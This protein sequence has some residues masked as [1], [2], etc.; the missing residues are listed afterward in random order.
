[1]PMKISAVIPAY[2]SEV[3]IGRA[4]D[5]VLKQTRPADEV[6]VVDDGST[7]STAEIIRSYGDKVHL[8][9]QE[10]AGVSV[11]RNA[12]VNA[13][14]GDWIAF[15]DADDEWLP[16]KLK[17]QTEHL[18]RNPDLKW[19]Y[20]NY[21]RKS[22]RF[23]KLKTAHVSSRLTGVLQGKE[24]VEDYFQAEPLGGHVWTCTLVV[25]KSVFEKSGMFEPGMKRA[26]DVDLWYRIAYQ[27]PMVGY[28]LDPLAIY[29]E[30]TPDSSTKVNDEV[31][32][33]V[34][35]VHRHE[36]LSKKH[37]RYDAF[38]PCI[39]VMVQVWIRQLIRKKRYAD[40]RVLLDCF[41]CYLPGRFKREMAFRLF[42][43]PI[44]SPIAQMVQRLKVILK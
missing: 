2:N 9:Q 32:F 21:Y 20:S 37:H 34:S 18:Q 30:D 35:L 27:Y 26:Q 43:P 15:L 29:H 41:K 44:C 19:T 4:I 25:H 3:T 38:R 8:F 11:A 12:G 5:S 33:M 22:P 23:Q 28:L 24:F 13:A 7:D 42:C 39:M 10:N 40:I 6:L 14:T 31:D 17:L 36:E 1:M 16:E